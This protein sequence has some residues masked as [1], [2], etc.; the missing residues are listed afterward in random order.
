MK[1][2]G[3]YPF[4]SASTDFLDFNTLIVGKME[5]QVV[6]LVNQSQVK[7]L[8]SVESV[9]DDGKDQSFK[10]SVKQGEIKPGASLDVSLTYEPSIVGV[11]THC[12]YLFKVLGGNEFKVACK[13]QALGIDVSLSA[14]SIH[15]GEV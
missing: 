5:S 4:L 3:K 8:F 13:G 10:L 9:D 2:I 12:Q 15:F 14:K 11:V 6:T 7:A 1:G